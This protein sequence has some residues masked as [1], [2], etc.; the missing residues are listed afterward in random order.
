MAVSHAKTMTIG[1]AKSQ[2]DRIEREARRQGLT[3][4][5]YVKQLI[6]SNLEIARTARTRT[7]AQIMGSPKDSVNEAE[8]DRLVDGAK[9][10]FH[11]LNK[12]KK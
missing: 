7:F 10:R 11:K 5:R 6:K 4:Q 8:L 9:T 12:K 3:P 1:L 2:V